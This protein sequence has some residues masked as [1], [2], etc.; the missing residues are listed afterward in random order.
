MN[1]EICG[2]NNDRRC[3]RLGECRS[4]EKKVNVEKNVKGKQKGQE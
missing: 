2:E 4:C 3:E 1:Q